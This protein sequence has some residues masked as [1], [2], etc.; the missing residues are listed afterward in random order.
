MEDGSSAEIAVVD[1]EGV[2]GIALFMGG[3]TTPAARWC[4]ARGMRTASMNDYSGSREF[5]MFQG[6]IASMLGVRRVGITEAAGTFQSAGLI[7]CRRG[8]MRVLDKPDLAKRAC[9]CYQGIR[10]QYEGLNAPLPR[11]LSRK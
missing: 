10:R 2:V 8:S 9:E 1:N 7:N 3:E 11:L 5:S 4:R 6:S